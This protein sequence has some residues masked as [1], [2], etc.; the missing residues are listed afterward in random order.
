MGYLRPTDGRT[1]CSRDCHRGRTP[2]S[3]EAGTDIWADFGTPLRAAEAGRV[4]EV[5]GSIFA[6]TGY[7]VTIDLDD[8][9]RIRY[10]H[11]WERYVA[12]GDRVARGTIFAQSG[13]SGYGS[14][15]AAGGP[16]TVGRHVHVTL[17]PTH[18][19]DFGTNARTLDFEAYADPIGSTASSG[20]T[21][22]EEELMGVLDDIRDM[23]DATNQA[24][25]QRTQAQHDVTR[26]FLLDQTQR[27]HDVTRGYLADL[28]QAQ[29]DVTRGYL[30]DTITAAV[31]KTSPGVDPG[32]VRDAVESAVRD[33]EV[34]ANVDID[35]IAK[36]V[37][38]EAD[39]R[40]RQRLN[41][42]AA[43]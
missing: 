6:A 8:G 5:G 30:V 34:E 39:K 15:T 25:E 38:D 3:Q 23:F 9:R 20:T 24:I 13:G 4:F 26:A 42:P 33:I 17:W 43:S 27:Q 2:P 32:V 11:L 10:L 19:Y 36:R 18:A 16:G 35:A 12:R 41:Q 1:L 29:H 28:T 14:M 22:E 7:F 31:A 37:N 21:S 40:A